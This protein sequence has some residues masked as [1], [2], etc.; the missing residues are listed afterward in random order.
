MGGF[1]YSLTGDEEDDDWGRIQEVSGFFEELGDGRRRVE[2]LGC[3]PRGPLRTAAEQVGGRR[4]LAGSAHLAFLDAAGAETGS[5]YVNHLTVRAARPSPRGEGLLDLTAELWCRDAHPGS[6]RPWQLVRSGQLD[7]P[8]L[9]HPLGPAERHAWL[10][11]ALLRRARGGPDQPPGATYHLDGEHVTDEESFYCALGEAVNG[12]GGYF[13]WNLDALDDCL[14]GGW[15]A[16]TPF[17][18][19][20]HCAGPSTARLKEI[21]RWDGERL[22]D[23]IMEIFGGR[24]V[25][26]VER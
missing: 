18:L 10:S 3:D 4:A 16:A 6:E 20:W 11:V 19:E 26:V 2:L 17:T 1:G 8:G 22:Y 12:P 21:V 25:E 23:T 9:W 13:G 7:R 15:G 14:R 24:R 5:Y